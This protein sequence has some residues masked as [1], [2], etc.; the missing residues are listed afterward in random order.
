MLRP[1][2]ASIVL[3]LTL[4]APAAEDAG[5]TVVQ[6]DIEGPVGPATADYVTRGLDHAAA[7]GA[8]L[9]LLRLDTPGGLDS[10]MR[11]IVKAIL[12]SPVPVACY[13]APSGARAASAGTF[14][15]YACHVAAMA[16]GTNLGA[17]TPVAMGAPGAPSPGDGGDA[18]DGD[19]QPGAPASAMERKAVND[20]VAYIRGLAE[21]RGR[22]ADWA[23]RAVR[24]AA[25]LSAE[26]ALKQNVTDVIAPDRDALL[27]LLHGRKVQAGGTTVTLATRGA[28]VTVMEPDWRVR[29]LAVITN[30][31]VAYILMLIGIYGLLL[32]FYN[33]GAI[34]PG[35]VG[36]ISLL[37]AL[38]AFQVL[39]VNYAGM[40]LILLGIGLMV[41]EAFMPSF[42]ML[43]VGGVVAFVIGSIILMD[44]E[45]PGYGIHGGIIAGVAAASALFFIF[46]V[47]FFIKARRAPVVSGAEELAGAEAEVVADFSGL[48][49][50]RLHGEHWRAEAEVPLRAG[51][52]VR[53]VGR[54]G[55]TLRVAPVDRDTDREDS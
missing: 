27:R 50:V 49:T 12:A 13:V 9:V 29:L 5:G 26:A 10:A 23:E 2:L 14:I 21:L 52:R 39:P 1:L 20:A 30:P 32:E 3:A 24:E 22:N 6:L 17:A 38:F 28:A 48:G 16:P 42:G 55:L 45:A 43:G 54:R 33:P 19:E 40:A 11:D 7:A 47:G 31:N 15:M 25:S 44:T 36:A 35:T 41:G 51:Q 46:V 8:G 18:Q 37:L 4:P 34:V 53:V